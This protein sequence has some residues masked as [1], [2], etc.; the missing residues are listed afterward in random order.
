MQ[1]INLAMKLLAKRRTTHKVHKKKGI[2]MKTRLLSVATLL[3]AFSS[4]NVF[5]ESIGDALE[6]CRNTDDS[7]KRLI[8]YD[9]VAKSLNQFDGVDAQVNQLSEYKMAKT[10]AGNSREQ[11]PSKRPDLPAKPA[12]PANE[13]GLEHKRDLA[14]EA[15]EIT[16]TISSFDKNSR[17]KHTITFSDGSIWRQTDDT[18]LK[19]QEGQV[20]SIERGLFGAFFLSVE[21]LNK[22][23]KVK[24]VK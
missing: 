7:L 3:C 16:V 24:R 15:S 23:M 22:R 17:D 18:Y 1:V 14:S 5:A 6:K 11:A 12:K 2:K 21:G 20:V 19:L 10:N 4:F 9:K 8:C 13:F